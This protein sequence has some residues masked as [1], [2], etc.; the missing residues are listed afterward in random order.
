M[1][2][3]CSVFSILLLLA[4]T[5]SAHAQPPKRVIFETDFTFDV[6][7]VGALAV[8]H[9]LADQGQVELVGIGYNEVHEYGLLAIKAVNAWY[10]RNRIPVAGFKGS[11]AN[12]DA[13]RYLETVAKQATTQPDS[14]YSDAVAM[15]E[16]VLLEQPNNSVV[17]VSVGFLNNLYELLLSNRELI[18]KKVAKLVVM[19]GL[20]ND[21]FNLTRHD[22]VT[23]SER[24]LR[25]WPT[26][27]VVVD[28]GENVLTGMSLVS[29]AESNPVRVAYDAW[30]RGNITGRP[31]W[32][33][34]AVL[35]AIYGSSRYFEEDISRSGRL[36]NG[37]EWQLD[38]EFRSYAKA[39]LSQEEFVA[40]IERLMAEPPK[41]RQ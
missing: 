37:Y 13:S 24:V 15:Y 38:G 20:V 21:D 2:V 14:T 34:V 39:K 11:L 36:K 22:L 31:S 35:Y 18:E 17:I 7:D 41:L 19:G 26:P 1:K 33:Q 12:P 32:D 16:S 6:D 10:G 30:F 28:Y 4:M 25:D 8:I 27:L 23:K 40:E 9:A 3:V 29:A 5:T